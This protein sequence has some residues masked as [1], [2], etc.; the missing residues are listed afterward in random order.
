[1]LPGERLVGGLRCSEVLARL[2]AFAE[3]TL[4]AADGARVASHV[5][6]CT[7]CERFGRHYADVIAHFRAACA[8]PDPIDQSATARLL[9][10]LAT[11]LN[12]N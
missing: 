11:R 3:G 10:R 7:V 2:D 4:D 6:D 9:A 1:M 5:A 8:E 12:A